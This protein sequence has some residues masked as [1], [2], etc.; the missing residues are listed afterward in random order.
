MQDIWGPVTIFNT[1]CHLSLWRRGFGPWYY[2]FDKFRR[3]RVSWY[4]LIWMFWYCEV[5]NLLI[6]GTQRHRFVVP[7]LLG[8]RVR[9]QLRANCSCVCCVSCGLL[10]MRPIRSLIYRNSTWSVYYYNTKDQL[11]DIT[12]SRRKLL[13]RFK[14]PNV[15]AL[16][17]C[18]YRCVATATLTV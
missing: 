6:F 16:G 12:I 11:N 17:S 9:N 10:S 1:V 7:R 18:G 15:T 13:H 5:S 8:S 3:L 4:N 14:W 2:V